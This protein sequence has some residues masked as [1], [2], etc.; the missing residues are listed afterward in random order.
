M[1][2]EERCEVHMRACEFLTAGMPVACGASLGTH[3]DDAR[4]VLY[5]VEPYESVGHI[6]IPIEPH[7]LIRFMQT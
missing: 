7:M 5:V 6:V 4:Y 1:A 2:R 3:A